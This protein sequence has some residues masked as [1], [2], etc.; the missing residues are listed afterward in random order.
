MSS[1]S[2]PLQCAWPSLSTAAPSREPHQP[3]AAHSCR[4]WLN[5]ERCCPNPRQNRL[6]APAQCPRRP[7]PLPRRS[8]HG[9]R[10]RSNTATPSWCSTAAATSARRPATPP[11]CS[12]NDTR[13]LSRLE[14]MVERRAAAAARLQ[15]ARRQFGVLRRSDQSRSDGRSAHRHG[16]GP[17]PHSAHDLSV[18]RHRLSAARRAQLRRSGDLDLRLSILFDN[19][20]AD[21]FEVRGAHRDKRGTATAKL[22]GDDRV[23]LV[24]HG[25]D[26]KV[27]RTALTSIRRRIG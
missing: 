17:G 2:I 13:H 19:D 27:R 16:K 14:L 18:A 11:A 22:H 3:K 12:I 4:R 9:R 24:Y 7:S 10:A 6:S 23:L 1:A 25:L 21:L 26:G 8:R 20:F 15:S 5:R